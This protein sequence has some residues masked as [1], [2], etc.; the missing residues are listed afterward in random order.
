M[1]RFS[2]LKIDGQTCGCLHVTELE[3]LQVEPNSDIL[4]TPQLYTLETM[5]RAWKQSRLGYEQAEVA[6]CSAR[7][8]M[9]G[10]KQ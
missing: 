8:A 3:Q 7:A 10:V 4:I 5:G 2:I 6:D 9:C 1:T